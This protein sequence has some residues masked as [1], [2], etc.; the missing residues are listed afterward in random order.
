[1]VAGAQPGPYSELALE[2]QGHIVK[3]LGLLELIVSW[4]GEGGEQ[5]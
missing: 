3:A 1:M 4:R 2:M 5:L